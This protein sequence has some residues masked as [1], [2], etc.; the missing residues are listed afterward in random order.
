METCGLC[1]KDEALDQVLC[2]SMLRQIKHSPRLP[3][4]TR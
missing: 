1:Y 2:L 4:L 3:E